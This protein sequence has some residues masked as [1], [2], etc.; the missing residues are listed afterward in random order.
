VTRTFLPVQN[1]CNSFKSL[2]SLPH[3]IAPD[4]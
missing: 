3:Q 1:M 4:Q 2:P